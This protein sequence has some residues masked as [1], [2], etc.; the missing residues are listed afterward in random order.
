M[1]P[2]EATIWSTGHELSAQMSA[3]VHRGTGFPIKH[4]SEAPLNPGPSIVYGI[5]RG[6]LPVMRR[7]T[8]SGSPFWYIDHS[9][10]GTPG[11]YRVVRDGFHHSYPGTLEAPVPPSIFNELG[12][13]IQPWRHEDNR[14][15]LVCPPSWHQ[16]LH[17]D[18]DPDEWTS[19]ITGQL[20]T[21]SNRPIIVRQKGVNRPLEIDLQDCFLVVTYASNAGIQ[22]LIDG[23]PVMATDHP[24]LPKFAVEFLENPPLPERGQLFR[25]LA[26]HEYTM[27]EI[28]NGHMGKRIFK[29]ELS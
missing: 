23:V 14:T 17:L 1:Q 13:S 5:L 24:S 21:H 7:C 2:I 4:V 20:A 18:V 22:A 11:R 9:Y 3:L 16:S 10:F 28:G 19:L 15:I 29:K 8:A 26:A 27:T 25:H 6:T 12:I